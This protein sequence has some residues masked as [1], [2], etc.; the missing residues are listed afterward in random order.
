MISAV[1]REELSTGELDLEDV[2]RKISQRP[3]VTKMGTGLVE[4][5]RPDTWFEL[6]APDGTK[7]FRIGTMGRRAVALG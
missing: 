5:D 7:V 6:I 2:A 4:E 3:R 1:S